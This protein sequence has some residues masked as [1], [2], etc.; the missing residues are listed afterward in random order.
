M[1]DVDRRQ[2]WRFDRHVSVGHLITTAVVLVGVVS[3]Y[4]RLEN[5]AVQNQADIAEIREAAGADRQFQI[6]QRVR[7]RDRVK[8]LQ[9][10]VVELKTDVA[11]L[12][13]SNQHIAGQIDRLVTHMV[14]APRAAQR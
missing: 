9:E 4:L 14:G 5:L 13:A 2:G 6:D 10:Q 12:R 3:G 7:V 8:E 1:Q 11:A